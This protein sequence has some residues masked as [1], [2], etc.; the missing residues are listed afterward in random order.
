MM[1]RANRAAAGAALAAVLLAFGAWYE[2]GPSHV[3]S[4]QPPLTVVT[5]ANLAG[6][7]GR[8]NARQ[9]DARLL[10]LLSPT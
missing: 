9:G 4:G 1:L 2:W 5:K 6:F 3:P 7:Q 10:L 8:F